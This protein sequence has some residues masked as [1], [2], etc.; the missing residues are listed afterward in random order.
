MVSMDAQLDGCRSKVESGSE[1]SFWGE[2]A[3][4]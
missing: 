4:R 2:V 3:W 1:L